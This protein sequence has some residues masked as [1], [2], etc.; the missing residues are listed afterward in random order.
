MIVE[1]IKWGYQEGKT[2]FGFG[3]DFAKVTGMW[4]TQSLVVTPSGFQYMIQAGFLS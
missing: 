2:L 3:Y 4:V 1:M